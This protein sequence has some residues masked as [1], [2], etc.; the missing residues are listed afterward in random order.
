MAKSKIVD[1]AR[2]HII[3]IEERAKI[4]EDILLIIDSVLGIE[5]SMSVSKTSFQTLRN[6]LLK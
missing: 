5:Q 1:E 6:S 4:A 3:G 2:D